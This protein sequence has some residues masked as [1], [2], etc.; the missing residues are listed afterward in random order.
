MLK[1]AGKISLSSSLFPANYLLAKH[2][3]PVLY[4]HIYRTTMS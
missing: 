2:M 4:E 1:T 3:G